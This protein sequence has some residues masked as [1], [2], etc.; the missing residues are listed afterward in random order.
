MII[1]EDGTGLAD[2]NSSVSVADADAYH[3]ARGNSAWTEASTSPDQGKAAAL[4]RGTAAIEAMIRNRLSGE[5]INGREQALLF[6]RSGMTDA[7]GEEIAEDEIPVEIVHAVCEASLRE[8]VAPGSMSP[9]LERGGQIRRLKAGS[10]EIEYGGNASAQTTFSIIDG[11]LAGLLGAA[12]SPYT[13][14]A[15]RG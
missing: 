11:I 13:A 5:K 12:P 6:P 9:D 10:V 8:L 2:A 15:V 14:S 3:S 1:V 4:I 7:D